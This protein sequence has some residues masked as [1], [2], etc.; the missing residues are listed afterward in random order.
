M[1]DLRKIY[2]CCEGYMGNASHG[3]IYNGLYYEVHLTTRFALKILEALFVL[4][5]SYVNGVWAVDKRT[6]MV[7]KVYYE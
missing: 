2:E 4:F 7:F 3:H 6:F 5:K 1:R